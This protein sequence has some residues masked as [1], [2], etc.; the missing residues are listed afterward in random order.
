[1]REYKNQNL[2][3]FVDWYYNSKSEDLPSRT[4]LCKELNMTLGE[5]KTLLQLFIECNYIYKTGYGYKVFQT[6]R[7]FED[8]SE[9]TQDLNYV[10]YKNHTYEIMLNKFELSL[11]EP[12]L[13]MQ[14]IQIQDLV[15]LLFLF[16]L[17]LKVSIHPCVEIENNKMYYKKEC[18]SYID[19]TV[20]YSCSFTQHTHKIKL[21]N[22]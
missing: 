1:M 21:T 9:V 7:F 22:I 6:K 2:K 12:E 8:P 20:L 15:Y 17:E 10:I 13:D 11:L 16:T 18:R 3:K 19:D 14:S 4:Y 5:F